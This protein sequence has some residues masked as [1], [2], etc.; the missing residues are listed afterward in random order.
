[1]FLVRTEYVSAGDG[2]VKSPRNPHWFL[3][4]SS[5]DVVNPA[6]S[7]PGK[8]AH[9]HASLLI[10]RLA[11]QF[12]AMSAVVRIARHDGFASCTMPALVGLLNKCHGSSQLLMPDPFPA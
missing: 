4:L 11:H 6:G 2:R 9:P 12:S 5:F 10:V 1:M 3:F 8:F 7:G